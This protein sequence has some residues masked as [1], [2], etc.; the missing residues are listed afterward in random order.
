MHVLGAVL[1]D[2]GGARV[3]L[4]EPAAAV[5][6][7]DPR[8][9]PLQRGCVED[10]VVVGNPAEETE[11]LRALRGGEPVRHVTRI[12]L[13]GAADPHGIDG[14]AT[15]R[16][17][18]AP[19]GACQERDQGGSSSKGGARPLRHAGRLRWPRA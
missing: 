15:R 16:H 12:E 11:K 6:A 18:S 2:A 1:D 10:R 14:R 8:Q 4:E 9:V 3:G 13:P 19:D 17:R 5:V 7:L